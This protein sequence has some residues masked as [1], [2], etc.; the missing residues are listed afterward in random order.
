MGLKFASG[1]TPG[2]LL[3]TVAGV[4][5]SRIPS[6]SV[7][8]VRSPRDT[9]LERCQD[10]HCGERFAGRRTKRLSVGPN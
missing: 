9:V 10:N 4:A 5:Y 7:Q 8:A 6:C 3:M 1:T 2:D